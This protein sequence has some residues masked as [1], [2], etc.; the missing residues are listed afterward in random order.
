MVELLFEPWPVSRTTRGVAPRSA[1]DCQRRF[2]RSGA[3][4]YS[5]SQSIFLVEEERRES[6]SEPR[7]R[8]LL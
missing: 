6:R 4:R 2:H 5:E 7:V 8:N 3:N 1:R